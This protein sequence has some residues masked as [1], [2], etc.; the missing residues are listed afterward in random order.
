MRGIKSDIF[1]IVNYAQKKTQTDI[2]GSWRISRSEGL[3]MINMC[4]E[5][6]Q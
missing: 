3:I 5:D 2:L 4:A 6:T 1:I